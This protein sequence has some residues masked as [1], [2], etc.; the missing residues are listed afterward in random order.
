MLESRYAISRLMLLAIPLL[1]TCSIHTPFSLAKNQSSPKWRAHQQSLSILSYY[2]TCGAFAYFSRQKKIYARFN[3]TQINA[4]HYQLI[5]TN[6]LGSTEISL[7]VQS[8]VAELVNNQGKRYVSNSPEV[9]IQKLTG[10]SIPLD[11]LRQ[12]MLG[13]PGN[14]TNFTIDSCGYLHTLNYSHNEQRWIVIYQGYHDNTFP[15]LPSNLEL[16][17][18]DNRIKLK[19][20]SWRL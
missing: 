3:W 13:L 10:M 19:M 11:N 6:P 8:G 15:A 17:Q 5:L 16:R 12:W 2:Q 1:T 20:D 14:A 18:G 7:N 4:D 9:I